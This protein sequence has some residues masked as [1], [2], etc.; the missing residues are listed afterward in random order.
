MQLFSKLEL[1][2]MKL[3]KPLCWCEISLTLLLQDELLDKQLPSKNKS[4]TE[5]LHSGF[6]LLLT[7]HMRN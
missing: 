2:I 4:D 5:S 6:T 3:C 1:K 7:N